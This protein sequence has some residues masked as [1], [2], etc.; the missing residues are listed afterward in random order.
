MTFADGDPLAPRDGSAFPIT[1]GA[2]FALSGPDGASSALTFAVLDAAAEEPEALA[3]QLIEKGCMQQL[4]LLSNA[5][6]VEEG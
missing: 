6:M 4:E 3:Q 2:S 1:D 5:T